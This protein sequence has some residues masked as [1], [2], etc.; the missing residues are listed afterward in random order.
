[1]RRRHAIARL[2][3]ALY[4]PAWR[5]EYGPE[6]IDILVSRAIAPSV[7]VDVVR[8]GL[9]QRGRASHPSTI[10][11]LASVAL[12]VGGFM[13]APSVHGRQWTALLQPVVTTFPPTT[14]RFIVAEIY[15]LSMVA[16]GCWSYLRDRGPLNRSGT[17]AMR[18]SL[19]AGLPIAI[20]ALLMLSGVMDRM[21]LAPQRVR[22]LPWL[23]LISPLL[24]LPEAWIWGAVGGL[25]GRWLSR[26][27]QP[28][29]SD[30]AT[31][32]SIETMKVSHGQHGKD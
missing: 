8:N 9:W 26:G 32:G 31:I 16:C 5:R 1:M 12:I 10:L 6:L 25:L 14:I 18:M 4:P 20:C 28:G 7:F 27:S 13:M 24:R 17:A 30:V 2:L 23:M 15:V 19:I 29:Y 21:F 11:G 3:V 22:P